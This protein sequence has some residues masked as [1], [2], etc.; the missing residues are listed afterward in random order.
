[1]IKEVVVKPAKQAKEVVKEKN[2]AGSRHCCW[3]NCWR[4]FCHK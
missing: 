2:L 3:R 4:N 1:M